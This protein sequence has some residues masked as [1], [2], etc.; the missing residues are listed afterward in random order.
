MKNSANEKSFDNLTIVI[1]GLKNL[2]NK[3]LD[4]EKEEPKAPAEEQKTNP[5]KI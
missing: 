1:I 3:Y 5:I 2:L 4:A